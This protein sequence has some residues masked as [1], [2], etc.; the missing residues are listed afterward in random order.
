MVGDPQLDLA[1]PMVRAVRG[2]KR[3]S[4]VPF[5]GL[6]LFTFIL[7]IAPQTFIPTLQTLRIAMLSAGLALG[8]Y[9]TDRLLHQQPLTVAPPAVRLILCFTLLAALSIP[10][11]QWP[12]GAF[13]TFFNELLKSVLIFV[14]VANVVNTVRRMKLMIWSM[15]LWAT[16][17]SWSAVHDFSEGNLAL[18]G[19][20]ISGYDSPLA[21]NPNDLALILNLILALTIGLY[22]A[23]RTPAGS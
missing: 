22:S 18:Q 5:W 12:G 10:F 3:S 1:T 8:V 16:V 23:L 2:R 4:S 6:M 19:L 11:A 14:L 20:R 7:L 9:V 15:A 13:D 17:M 21:A